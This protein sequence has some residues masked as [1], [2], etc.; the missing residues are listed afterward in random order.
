MED[1]KNRI[2][3]EIYKTL[4]TPPDPPLPFNKLGE[5]VVRQGFV[6]SQKKPILPQSQ[7][8][9]NNNKELYGHLVIIH[10][11]YIDSSMES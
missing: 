9:T 11:T 5:G 2:F 1:K 10:Y 4:Y 8:F 3:D 6:D 7:I